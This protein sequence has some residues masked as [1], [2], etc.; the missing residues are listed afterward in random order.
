MVGG[1]VR[2]KRAGS[3][4]LPALRDACSGTATR[5]GGSSAE[6]ECR[7]RSDGLTGRRLTIELPQIASS[8]EHLTL[9]KKNKPGKAV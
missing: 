7:S 4:S 3:P 1:G 5:L 8:P 6:K 2:K 9:A